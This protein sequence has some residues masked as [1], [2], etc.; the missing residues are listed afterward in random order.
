MPSN[1]E[2]G[3]KEVSKGVETFEKPRP[4][5]KKDKKPGRPK[6]EKKE[7]KEEKA[8][9]QKATTTRKFRALKNVIM[10]NKDSWD[11]GQVRL[12]V[13]DEKTDELIKRGIIEIV[14]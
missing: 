14:G 4:N 2:V 1:P 13:P 8:E 12:L 9:S 11:A 7:D 5:D 3:K 10:G 6:K